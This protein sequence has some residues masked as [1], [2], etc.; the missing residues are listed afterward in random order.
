MAPRKRNHLTVPRESRLDEESDEYLHSKMT[1]TTNRLPKFQPKDTHF[2]DE[3]RVPKRPEKRTA[4]E[5]WLCKAMLAKAEKDGQ[6]NWKL[7]S[8]LAYFNIAI[9]TGN[10]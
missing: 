9:M 3:S 8:H 4:K 2:F 1:K 7:W 10:K 6:F 5:C